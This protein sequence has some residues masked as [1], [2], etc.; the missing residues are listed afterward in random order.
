M[1]EYAHNDLWASISTVDD[2]AF[3]RRPT[4]EGNPINFNYFHVLRH[5]DRDLNVRILAKDPQ[6]DAWHRAGFAAKSGYDPMG[7]GFNGMGTGYGYTAAD[8]D[9]VTASRAA[10]MEYQQMLMEETQ[11]LLDSLDEADL[12][13]ERPSPSGSALTTAG[14]LQHLITHTYIH[15]GDIEYIKGLLGVP[16]V[17][18]PNIS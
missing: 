9:S 16:N 2:A 10:L 14:R 3:A 15:V 11:A 7:K 18:V 5:W 1:I 8:V 13:V 4:P 17:D 12:T 6:Q